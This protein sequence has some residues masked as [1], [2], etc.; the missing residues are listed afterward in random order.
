MLK[1]CITV[2]QKIFYIFCCDLFPLLEAGEE[3]IRLKEQL[4]N[5]QIHVGQICGEKRNSDADRD[6]KELQLQSEVSAMKEMLCTLTEQKLNF[7]M[8]VSVDVNTKLKP[9]IFVQGSK[10][11]LYYAHVSAPTQPPL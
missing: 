3:V 2:L 6:Q 5:F 8:E 10:G 7:T 9:N 4:N 1:L 11:L